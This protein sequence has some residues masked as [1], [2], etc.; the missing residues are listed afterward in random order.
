[1]HPSD[2][3]HRVL[4]PQ[5][6]LSFSSSHIY[7]CANTDKSLLCGYCCFI[8]SPHVLAITGRFSHAFCYIYNLSHPSLKLQPAEISLMFTLPPMFFALSTVSL[9]S[10]I[11][12][13]PSCVSVP[14][15]YPVIKES[16]TLKAVEKDRNTVM[17]CKAEGN[18]DPTI[19]WLKDLIPVDLSDPR[20]QLLQTGEWVHTCCRNSRVAFPY[21][22]LHHLCGQV[23]LIKGYVESR[24]DLRTSA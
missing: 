2:W 18:P 20:L 15:G 12:D 3:M 16:P 11:S 17:V 19:I 23:K 14:T 7:N 4:H 21:L 22:E 8:S 1:M 10:S 24:N 5:L 6:I 9:V 13:I